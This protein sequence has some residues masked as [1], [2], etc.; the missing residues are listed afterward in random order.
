[1]GS[2]LRSEFESKHYGIVGRHSAVEICLWNKRSLSCRGTCYKEKFYGVDAHRCAQITPAVAWCEQNCVHCWRPME[3]FRPPSAFSGRFDEPKDIVNGV[4]EQRRKLLT[5][6]GGN[7][8]VPRARYE[9]SL[10]P[11]HWAISLS[12]EATL[13]PKL[14]ELIKEIRSLPST[15]TVFLVTNGQEPEMVA[16]PGERGALP[17]QLYVSLL[18]YDEQS[19]ARLCAPYY[20][21]GW[22]RLQETLRVWKSLKTRRVIRITHVKGLNDSDHAAERFARVIERADPHFVEVK[23]YMHIGYSRHRLS[24]GNMPRFAEVLEFSERILSRLPGYALVSHD[25]RSRV[26]LLARSD[27][28]GKIRVLD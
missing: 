10:V 22:Q 28:S 19:F 7:S 18:G 17:T 1:M 24:R 13:Y 25:E 2:R 14:P 26:V 27:M 21:D 16:A 8:N 3:L 23:S 5:G 6:F 15:K 12:G 9:E 20:A 4:L 11:T